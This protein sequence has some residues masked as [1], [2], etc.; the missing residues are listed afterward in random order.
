MGKVK[1]KVVLKNQPDAS[2][3]RQIW[4]AFRDAP[5]HRRGALIQAWKERT[6]DKD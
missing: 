3:A 6:R 5:L 4:L 1:P 2:E